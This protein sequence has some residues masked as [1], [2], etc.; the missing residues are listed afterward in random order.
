MHIPCARSYLFFGS[1]FIVWRPC[2]GPFEATRFVCIFQ[3][4]AILIP[5]LRRILN[6]VASIINGHSLCIQPQY[7][8]IEK[9]YIL[10]SKYYSPYCFQPGENHLFGKPLE[11]QPIRRSNRKIRSVGY[12][13]LGCGFRQLSHT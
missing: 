12:T 2:Y 10:L 1:P 4:G 6:A 13:A 5:Y 8:K 3:N 7:R 9:F 11:N